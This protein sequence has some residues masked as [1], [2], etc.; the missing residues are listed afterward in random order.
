M[1]PINVKKS[2]RVLDSFWACLETL[3]DNTP[4]FCP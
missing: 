2:K 3:Y 4:K 1:L